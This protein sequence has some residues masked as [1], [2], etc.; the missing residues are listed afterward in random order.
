MEEEKVFTT[1]LAEGRRDHREESEGR[2]SPA[3]T[4]ELRN[5]TWS[6]DPR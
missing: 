1:G 3:P 6:G 2:A 4:M 5:I